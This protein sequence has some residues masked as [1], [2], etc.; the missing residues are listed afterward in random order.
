MGAKHGNRKK[1]KTY[2]EILCIKKI[3]YYK[4]H[5]VALLNG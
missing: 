3:I 1:G 2:C 4:H 5:V